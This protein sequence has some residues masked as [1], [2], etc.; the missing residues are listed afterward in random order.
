MGHCN[1]DQNLWPVKSF[2]NFLTTRCIATQLRLL[3]AFDPLGFFV[4]KF[5]EDKFQL[6]LYLIVKFCPYLKVLR[7]MARL[8]EFISFKKNSV[9]ILMFRVAQV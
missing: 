9:C 4:F 5:S 2:A 8:Q 1:P 3:I 7:E 6:V